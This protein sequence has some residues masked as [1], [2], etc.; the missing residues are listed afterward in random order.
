MSIQSKA[1]K[2][3]DRNYMSLVI[4]YNQYL[5]E[6]SPSIQNAFFFGHF[7]VS[8]DLVNAYN[9]VLIHYSTAEKSNREVLKK[10]M[11]LIEKRIDTQL[12]DM[13]KFLSIEFDK[14]RKSN[15]STS[16]KKSQN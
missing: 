16:D 13:N 2:I 8:R 7:K 14:A 15:K 3:I 12:V 4:D 6:L 9:S 11:D 5:K 10:S 1:K